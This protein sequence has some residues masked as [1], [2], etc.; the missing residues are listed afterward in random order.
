[1][2]TAVVGGSIHRAAARI[3]AANN[4]R[5][6]TPMTSHRRKSRKKPF[7][8]AVVI[9]VFGIAVTWYSRD[10]DKRAG[11]SSSGSWLSDQL[12]PRPRCE[13]IPAGYQ[14]SHNSRID[15]QLLLPAC[16]REWE[17]SMSSNPVA[18]AQKRRSSRIDKAFM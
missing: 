6:A 12:K 16:T 10:M 2:C 15:S 9:S 11:E 7:R 18:Y 8:G 5:S 1:M 14:N 13:T 3:S 17:D 4:Q